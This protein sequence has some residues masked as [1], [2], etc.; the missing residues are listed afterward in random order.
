VRFRVLAVLGA[1]I[2]GACAGLTAPAVFAAQ[3]A[4][5]P[6][7]EISAEASAAVQRMGE[8]LRAKEFSFHAQ[9][10]R[11]Y[12]GPKGEPLHIFH[13]LEVTVRRPDRLLV[14][15][16]GDDGRSKLS[17]G[18][19]TL[20]IYQQEGNK[21]ASI[22]VPGTLEGMMKEAMGRLGIDFPL[23]DFLSDMP[24][25]AFLSGVTSGE[26]VGTVMIDGS[27][28][29]HMFFQQP[30]GM[31]LE[32]WVDKNPPSVPRRLIVTYRSV[33][34]QPGFIAAMSDWDFSVH[35][36]DAEF[37]FQPPPGAVKVALPAH[38]AAP[39]GQARVQGGAK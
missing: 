5:Q 2:G 12:A 3:P 1:L 7:P 33:P 10:I 39:A 26:V 36:S 35:P 11:V 30:R 14:V 20:N 4:G 16:S 17:Y 24:D 34:G 25:K 29:L 18:G 31:E 19:K 8:T 23:A 15:R 22:P 6:K 28:T 27:P 37:V 13:T 32:L 38:A 21:Y 9:T